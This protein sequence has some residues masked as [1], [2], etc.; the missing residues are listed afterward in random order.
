MRNHPGLASCAVHCRHC[1]IRFLTHP[2]NA[3]RRDLRCP[4]GCRE[5]HRRQLANQRSKKHYR[6]DE[7]RWNK[8]LLNAKRSVPGET[9]PAA[10]QG[11]SC[12]DTPAR[13]EGTTQAGPDST[14][15]PTQVELE[16][17]SH[18][19][20]KLTLDGFTLDSATLQGVAG[21]SGEGGCS[22]NHRRQ[23]SGCGPETISPLRHRC[24]SLYQPDASRAY[25]PTPG[26]G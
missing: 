12:A 18:A 2:R 23:P 20:V 5:Q 8:K 11:T 1:S 14:H 9:A 17:T 19:D 7:G 15:Q 21:R 6:T 25:A 4:F 24:Q 10:P 26:P 3:N 22:R 13:H 16:E